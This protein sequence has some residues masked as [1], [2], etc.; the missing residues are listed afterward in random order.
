[1]SVFIYCLSSDS[2]LHDALLLKIF[3]RT[4]YDIPP[5]YVSHLFILVLR[6]ANHIEQTLNLGRYLLFEIAGLILISPFRI[7][8]NRQSDSLTA[9]LSGN[10]I[11]PEGA[12]SGQLIFSTFK[13]SLSVSTNRLNDNL[14][15]QP[16]KT[17]SCCDILREVY[18]IAS[19]LKVI[20]SL[21][22][23]R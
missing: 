4:T 14:N 3:H 9:Q 16:S 21:K 12:N 17:R 10:H 1:M 19:S 22:R 8:R 13:I 2:V 6:Y 5:L 7:C 11:A 18:N 23:T 15:R 20:E